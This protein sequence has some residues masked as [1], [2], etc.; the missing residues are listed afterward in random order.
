MTLPFFTKAAPKV[1]PPD[2]SQ[3]ELQAKLDQLKRVQGDGHADRNN[4]E[5]DSLASAA[6]HK[7]AAAEFDDIMGVPGDRQRFVETP[8]PALESAK[9]A[10]KNTFAAKKRS[11]S[12]LA[13]HKASVD[14]V[15][16]AKDI[17]D[18][19]ALLQQDRMG[20]EFEAE[21]KRTVSFAVGLA[22]SQLNLQGMIL[23][24]RAA[25][26]EERT[27][28]HGTI[29]RHLGLTLAPLLPAGVVLPHAG[30]LGPRSILRNDLLP[31]IGVAHP[32]ILRESLPAEADQI[33][34]GAEAARANGTLSFALPGGWHIL[35]R[36]S[37][38]MTWQEIF[39][40]PLRATSRG[41]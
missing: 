31:A 29:W 35:E 19:T 1:T 26:P 38:D 11:D 20:S 21:A 25:A 12:A 13:A 30:P 4:L 7:R 8:A 22:Q 3:E 33:I 36:Q 39:S 27:T 5:A 24:A 18:L 9:L 32:E 2:P 34:S 10:W 28:A 37:K 41:L 6:A 15:S 40:G 17:A 23:R 16:G 14:L